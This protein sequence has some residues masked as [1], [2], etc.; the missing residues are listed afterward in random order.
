[1][2]AP[3]STPAGVAGVK[4]SALVSR[5]PGWTREWLTNRW[6][7]TRPLD[8]ADAPSMKAFGSD[9]SSSGR[10]LLED[11]GPRAAPSARRLIVLSDPLTRLSLSMSSNPGAY[12]VLIGSGVSTGA[13]MPTGW[14]VQVDLMA[15]VASAEGVPIDATD[16]DAIAEWRITAHGTNTT[17]TTLLEEFAATPADRQA[18]LRSYFVATP[19]ERQQRLK[20]PGPAHGSL[21]IATGA[22][23]II[24]TT[25]FDRLTERASAHQSQ[26]GL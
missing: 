25:N 5:T 26:T 8:T 14:D 22:V 20:V 21:A 13:G 1:M 2:T 19:E 15:R 4:H 17:Y 12:A 7:G 16:G 10:C 6:S 11:D 3:A 9:L 18:L 24:L 23:R